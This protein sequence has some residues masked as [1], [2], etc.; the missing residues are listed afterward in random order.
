MESIS[1]LADNLSLIASMLYVAVFT[2]RALLLQ[3]D[4]PYTAAYDHPSIDWSDSRY[5]H[6]LLC[7]MVNSKEPASCMCVVGP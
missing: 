6:D 3:E 2:R 5:M 4:M 7:V 1:G